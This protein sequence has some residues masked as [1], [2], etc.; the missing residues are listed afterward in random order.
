MRLLRN[1]KL[2][3]RL[4]LSFMILSIACVGLVALGV[5]RELRPQFLEAV[6]LTLIDTSRVLASDLAARAKA[7]G[8][9]QQAV[10]EFTESLQVLK[11]TKFQGRNSID[12][13]SH[14]RLRIF[15]TDADGQLLLD[16]EGRETRGTDFSH[17]RDVALT[18]RGR[19][20]ARATRENPDD[21][22]T[23]IHFI[24]APIVVDQKI[25]GVLSIGKPVESVATQIG[26]NQTLL[27]GLLILT[28]ALVALPLSLFATYWISR[29]VRRLKEYVE[30]MGRTQTLQRPRLA[31]DEIGFLADAIESLRRRLDAKQYIESYVHNLTHEMKSPLTGILGASE[32]LSADQLA[33]ADRQ[34]LLQNIEGDAQRLRD[35]ADRLLELASLEAREGQLRGESF[36]LSLL[37][38]EVLESFEPQVRSFQTSHVEVQIDDALMMFGERF[39]IWRAM[40]NLLQN[41]IDFARNEGLHIRIRAT[42]S[43]QAMGTGLDRGELTIEIDDDGV[44]LPDFAK[45]RATERFFS[46]ERPRTGKKSSGLGLSFVQEILRLHGGR[47]EINGKAPFGCRARLSFPLPLGDQS[48]N[49]SARRSSTNVHKP[50]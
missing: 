50:N 40:A 35:L 5:Y 28:L 46:T 34:Q 15:I 1:L 10:D 32:L 2:R 48:Q 30:N 19:Y 21:P 43:M 11:S 23:S 36:N 42:H 37:I 45:A 6:E 16:S 20:G 26:R 49:D 9:I 33:P 41:S 3:T 31:H 27:G 7:K 39:L 38:D 24:A 29:P 14:L 8:S 4:T 25:S 22:R 44:G 17:W 18:L 12:R 47:F 13:S